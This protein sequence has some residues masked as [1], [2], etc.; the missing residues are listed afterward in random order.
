MLWNPRTFWQPTVGCTSLLSFWDTTLSKLPPPTLATL[1]ESLLQ[2]YPPLPRHYPL[3]FLN[4][5]LQKAVS[6][7]SSLLSNLYY[8]YNSINTWSSCSVSA[9]W[10]VPPAILSILTTQYPLELLIPSHLDCHHWSTSPQNNL[11]LPMSFTS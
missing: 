10:M 5:W 9:S 2:A 3:E 11:P 6:F 4:T 1:F 8:D 7:L